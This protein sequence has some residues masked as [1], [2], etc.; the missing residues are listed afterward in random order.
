LAGRGKIDHYI[1]AEYYVKQAQTLIPRRAIRIYQFSEIEA[2]KTDDAL[3]LS[4]HR[5][6]ASRAGHEP[7]LIRSGKGFEFP[8]FIPAGPGN[9]ETILAE[10]TGHNLQTDA[11]GDAESVKAVM[12]ME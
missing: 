2:N 3:H 9:P 7:L 5:C 8:G 1:P 12:A 10:I 11:P 4:R 6:Y